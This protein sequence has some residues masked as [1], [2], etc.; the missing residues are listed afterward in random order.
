MW[1]NYSHLTDDESN[2]LMNPIIGLMKQGADLGHSPGSPDSQ[3]SII[4]VP[5]QLPP[6]S[7]LLFRE[8]NSSFRCCIH[9]KTLQYT[10]YSVSN[11]YYIL[12]FIR[13]PCNCQRKG[14]KKKL[15]EWSEAHVFLWRDP[16]ER[17]VLGVK[18]KLMGLS[19]FRC[20]ERD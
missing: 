8:T 13:L 16:C 17:P 14:K 19:F 9:H 5:N 20:S 18:G 15:R 11:T 7:Q 6:P 12:C 4:S 10:L 3:A 1:Q 2:C